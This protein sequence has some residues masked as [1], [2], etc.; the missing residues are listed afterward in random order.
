LRPDSTPEGIP[1]THPAEAT[2]RELAFTGRLGPTAPHRTDWPELRGAA[3]TLV[4]PLVWHRHT[5]RIEA[6]RGHRQCAAALDQM[7]DQCLD[8]FED[9]VE[10]VVDYLFTNGRRPIHN[11]EG[12]ITSRMAMATVDGH[13]KRRGARG[14]LQR[15]RVPG[16]LIDRLDADPWLVSLAASIIEW[17]GVP[18]TA[19]TE[20]WPLDVWTDRRAAMVGPSD[21]RTGA[22]AADVEHVLDVMRRTR[23][24]WYEA[25]IEGPLG[26]KQPPACAPV[27]PETPDTA[28]ARAERADD[29]LIALAAA[30][31]DA[32]S[33][34]LAEGDDPAVAVPRVLG[35]LFLGPRSAAAALDVPPGDGPGD[36]TDRLAAILTDEAALARLVQQVLSVV[37]G[38]DRP[39]GR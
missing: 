26:R 3:Y 34:A 4:W 5:R 37:N 35:A 9:D 31:T 2:L 14:A 30:A 27:Q 6:G 11:L 33:A 7:A 23:P 39:V 19:G 8:R 28:R 18:V 15:I 25:H 29:N 36:G 38:A 10:A 20:L 13:R 22:V 16:W 17:V 12:W 32:I 1:R 21:T 24:A